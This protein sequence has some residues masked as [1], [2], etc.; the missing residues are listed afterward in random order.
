V[1]HK[2]DQL[3]SYLR[4]LIDGVLE[5]VNLPPDGSYLDAVI[6]GQELYTGNEIRIGQ[7]YIVCV[8]I[9]GFPSESV[10]QILEAID[11]IPASLRFSTR[12]LHL[13]HQEAL[14]EVKKYRRHWKQRQRGF[15][16]QL[17]RS[18]AKQGEAIDD[19]A[20][21]M[22]KECDAAAKEINGGLV[23]G[24][25]YTAN[26]VLR[27]RDRQRALK[28]ADEVR[29]LVTK[30]GFVARIETVNT[31][32]A[33]LG[34]LPGHTA[35]NVRRPPLQT[36]RLAD[37]LPLTSVWTGADTTPNPLYPPNSPPLLHAVAAGATPFR[38]SLDG[39]ILGF[40]PTGAGKS[41]M[42]AVIATQAR[43]YAGMRVWSFDYKRGMMATAL[44]CQ[45]RHYDIGNSSNPPLCPFAVLD[46]ENDVSWA[47]S[48][49]GTCFELQHDREPDP[50]ERDAIYNALLL[51]RRPGEGRSMTHFHALVQNQAV[52][53]AMLFYT[54]M[55]PAG[56]LLDAEEDGIAYSDF[57]VFEMEDLLGRGEAT[58]IPTLLTLFRRFEMSLTG[59]PAL[60]DLQE[61]W[62]LLLHPVFRKKIWEWLRT[63]RSKNV[64]VM[65][66]TQ[67][68]G[69][70]ME[71]GMLSV[72]T[73]NCP[74]TFYLPNV[75]AF[76]RGS[77]KHPGPYDFYRAKGLNDVQISIIQEATYKQDY[78]LVTPKGARLF[79]LGVGPFT[80]RFTGATSKEDADR[81]KELRRVH[82]ERWLYVWLDEGGIAHEHLLPED[83]AHGAARRRRAVRELI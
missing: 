10:P 33:W 19:H 23:S 28:L 58:V 83:P 44:A 8:A 46:T 52:K 66:W 36:D 35:P 27:D 41:T 67:S 50:T 75:D 31:V 55:G 42:E 56:S 78:Y 1:E 53:D 54:G 49:A 70:V 64:T 2:R 81:I 6:C 57:T 25:F 45:G 30:L 17:V 14:A 32:E 76:V 22:V 79:S 68:L 80:K 47:A 3:V 21:D 4:F 40:G 16:S 82:G 60:L 26:V 69:E 37:L 38:F 59:T 34:S 9:E 51:M 48:L 39:H 12:F 29:K 24:G 20:V 5:P 13:D 61:A 77:D 74:N 65:L 73:E 43:R 63:M 7:D 71:S 72:L 15:V 11:H 18:N 62:V